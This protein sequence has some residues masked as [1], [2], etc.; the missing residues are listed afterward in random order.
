MLAPRLSVRVSPGSDVW[1]K[2]WT[3]ELAAH[4]TGR[5]VGRPEGA[6]GTAG[7]RC[8][9]GSC[10]GS[11]GISRSMVSTKSHASASIVKSIGLKFTSQWKQRPRLVRG[12]T[13]AI[14]SPHLG[15]WNAS[16]PARILWGH[17]QCSS[18]RFHSMLLRSRRS[19]SSGYRDM[20]GLLYP[21]WISLST[22]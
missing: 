13:T 9:A 22:C 5:P 16:W 2:S 1:Q 6:A 17:C 20:E 12:F 7:S 21:R 15:H 11:K 14:S 10:G 19:R 3:G 4:R 8:Y 18:R